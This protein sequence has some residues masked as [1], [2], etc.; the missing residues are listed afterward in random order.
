[1]MEIQRLFHFMAQLGLDSA[2]AMAFALHTADPVHSLV[3]TPIGP[4]NPTKG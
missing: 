1:M 3:P 2:A 4:S